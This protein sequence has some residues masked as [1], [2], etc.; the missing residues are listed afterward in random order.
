MRMLFKRFA[1]ADAA[2]LLTDL[3]RQLDGCDFTQASV[4]TCYE[5]LPESI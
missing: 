2:V 1:A 3:T 5:K 4:L